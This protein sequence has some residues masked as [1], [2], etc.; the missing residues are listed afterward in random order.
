MTND[1]RLEGN[2][3]VNLAIGSLS[4]NLDGRVSINGTANTHTATITDDE[5]GV[6]NFMDDDSELENDDQIQNA[7]LT[8]TP[9]ET[10]TGNVGLDVDLTV[11]ATDTGGGS[12]T[13][14]TDYAVYGS[15]T[16]TFAAGDATGTNIT[17]DDATLNVIDDQN[18]EPDETV[19]LQIEF[20]NPSSTLGGLVSIDDATHTATINNNDGE[21]TL[22]QEYLVTEPLTF[23][24]E[25]RVVSPIMVV[26]TPLPDSTTYALVRHHIQN[27]SQQNRQLLLIKQEAD[28]TVHELRPLP[29]HY[30][31]NLSG[32]LDMLK[33]KKDLPDG[34]YS[35][36]LE[37][38]G[39]RRKIIEF[40]KSGDSLS[41]PLKEPGR[42]ANPQPENDSAAPTPEKPTTQIQGFLLPAQRQ[43]DTSE[44]VERRLDVREKQVPANRATGGKNVPDL[45][46]VETD[47]KPLS[48]NTDQAVDPLVKNGLAAGAAMVALRQKKRDD[49]TSLRR[50]KHVEKDSFSLASR[51]RR[52][53]R[54]EPN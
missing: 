53:L 35:L 25:V 33:G 4:D 2:E 40:V 26:T 21:N 15:Q 7:T 38:S 48:F 51:I 1:R 41:D 39:F 23:V 43:N 36:I 5:K 11:V 30:L 19:K 20:S 13:S 42:G 52:R 37:E 9:N 50:L 49:F 47:E 12:A 22:Q 8:I 46:K 32:L 10:G 24:V 45:E 44:N 54:G 17:S 29:L 3:T 14:V 31:Q 6:I 27:N 18:P 16:L 34:F 28:G